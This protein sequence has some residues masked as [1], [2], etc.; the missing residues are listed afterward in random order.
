MMSLRVQGWTWE[1]LPMSSKARK[2]LPCFSTELEAPK[3]FY[4]LNTVPKAYLEALLRPRELLALG[5]TKV[6]HG[7]PVKVY[8]DIL[9]GKEYVVQD[10]DVIHFRFNV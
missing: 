1:L 9:E 2:S 3:V 8:T 6:P 10:G 4:T 7:Q 5:V